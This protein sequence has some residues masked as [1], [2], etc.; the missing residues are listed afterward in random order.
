MLDQEHG[1]RSSYM[2]T[3][4]PRF[5]A[6]TILGC[7]VRYPDTR[8]GADNNTKLIGTELD[9]QKKSPYITNQNDINFITAQSQPSSLYYTRGTSRIGCAKHDC[10]YQHIQQRR[11]EI[12]SLKKNSGKDVSWEPSTKKYPFWWWSVNEHVLLPCT[13]K[14]GLQY[15]PCPLNWRVQLTNLQVAPSQAFS[16]TISSKPKNEFY[17]NN[18]WVNYVQYLHPSNMT[19]PASQ[20]LWLHH[21]Y[22]MWDQQHLG[23]APMWQSLDH[24]YFPH[25]DTVA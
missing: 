1:Q 14:N 4:G 20:P 18:L 16:S 23:F 25:Q 6:W 3:D 21:G 13:N 17:L 5:H 12:N 2:Y 8:F 22:F 11:R 7:V 19:L 10:L 24:Q 9:I 15:K